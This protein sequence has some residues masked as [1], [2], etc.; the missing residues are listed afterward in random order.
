MI[1]TR[2][3]GSETI[4]IQRSQFIVSLGYDIKEV[5]LWS[6]K[7]RNLI[8]GANK[9]GR[10][11][12]LSFNEYVTLASEANIGANQIGKKP[13]LYQMGRMGDIGDY[14][15]G[16]CRFIT[17]K[18]NL[19][20]RAINGGNARLGAALSKRIKGATKHTNAGVAS[21]AIKMRDNNPKSKL[22]VLRSPDGNEYSDSN[23]TR[24]CETN[25]LS[26][27]RIYEILRGTREQFKGWTGEYL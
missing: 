14:V 23:V 3:N 7:W 22:F 12:L 13:H 2:K 27:G 5:R 9:S 18:Q 26:V 19:D 21:M 8:S 24:F 6:S 11:C 1:R 15:V 25:G 20:E 4:M 17:M 10:K 16:N